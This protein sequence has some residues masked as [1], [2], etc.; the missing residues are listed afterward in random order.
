MAD[1]ADYMTQEES[2]AASGSEPTPQQ[3]SKPPSLLDNRNNAGNNPTICPTGPEHPL[4]FTI[5]TRGQERGD[6]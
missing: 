6:D 4:A 1:R 5:G 2:V 3:F